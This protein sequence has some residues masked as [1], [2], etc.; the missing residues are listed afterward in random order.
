MTYR[1]FAA[2]LAGCLALMLVIGAGIGALNRG[3]SRPEGVAEDWLTAVGDSARKGVEADATKRAEKIGPTATEELILLANGGLRNDSKGKSTFPD[4]EVGKAI[5]SPLPD[6]TTEATVRFRA[7]ARR[8]D[9]IV[10]LEGHIALRDSTGPWLVDRVVVVSVDDKA[11]DSAGFTPAPPELASDGGPPP[12]SAPNTL[13]LLAL[14]IG[15]LVT[16]A[17]SGLVHLA[18]RELPQPLAV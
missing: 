4:L 8:G 12:S 15:V 6:G 2:G 3:H 10:K 11:T 9:D 14:V 7:H 18:G 5:R 17:A 13:W 16:A 1:Q